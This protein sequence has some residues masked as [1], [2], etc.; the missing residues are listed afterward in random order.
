MTTPE[1]SDQ[2]VPSPRLDKPI[3]E[4]IT[5]LA[6]GTVVFWVTDSIAAGAV[7]PSIRAGWRSFRTGWWILRSD[8]RRSRSWICS[9]FC[10]ATGFWKGAAAALTTIGVLAAEYHLTGKEP[11]NAQAIPVLQRLFAGILLTATVGLLAAL[12]AA[13]ARVRIWIHPLLREWTRGDFSAMPNLA[14]GHRLNH[15]MF[16]LATSLGCPMLVPMYFLLIRPPTPIMLPVATIGGAFLT[17]VLYGWLA[18]RIIATDPRE[19]WLD[20]DSDW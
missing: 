11:D 14:V 9:A 19:C 6:I 15:A 8:H 18:S 10:F 16:V 3:V 2:R 4:F 13:V 17:I 7:M 5:F 1:I 12:C 20:V